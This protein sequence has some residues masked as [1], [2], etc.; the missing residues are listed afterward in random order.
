METHNL[1]HLEGIPSGHFWSSLS[2]A[3]TDP[4]TGITYITMVDY[5]SLIC[6]LFTLDY[7]N[8][9]LMLT[10]VAQ[11]PA[12]EN[13]YGLYIPYTAPE[14]PG[15]V[16]NFGYEDSKIFFTVPTKTYS[17]KQDLTGS[18]TAV[19]TVDGET[20]EMAVTPGQAVVIDKE[21]TNDTHKFAVFIRNAAGDGAERRS[22]TFVG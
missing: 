19:V 3:Y 10:Q 5:K 11:T 17:S 21:V 18:L 4:S 14:A 13:A 12:N 20:T 7:E 8:D 6:Y 9:G 16:T 1:G 2:G 15:A 22:K